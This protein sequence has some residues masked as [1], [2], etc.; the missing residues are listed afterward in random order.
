MLEATNEG[1]IGYLTFN[2][3]PAN[4]YS[5]DFM[6]DLG[7]HIRA[8]AADD[9]VRVVIVRSALERFFSAGAD[10]KAF[11]ANTPEQNMEMVQIAHQNLA[12]IAA[13]P[14]LFIAQIQGNALGGGLEM[15]LACDLRFGAEGQYMLGLPE[16]TLGLL[17]GNG[18]TQ[19]LP[20]LI[21][22]AKALDL[23]V[24]GRRL[25]PAEAYTLGILDRL[26]PVSEVADQTRT[27][28]ETIANGATQAIGAIKLAVM[29]GKDLALA[30]GLAVERE[31]LTPL[32]RG[33]EAR[34]G[35]SAFTEKRAPNYHPQ[36]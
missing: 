4:S 29:R 1:P 32:F 6:R 20:R 14:K 19:R 30:D 33:T 17:P 7:N 26:F 31:L 23:M 27:F 9:R 5:I 25:T 12:E 24:T 10:I 13:T 28:A 22:F 35:L 2:N 16:A 15:A 18:G 11:L 36:Q 3:P 8:F 34:E 21:G